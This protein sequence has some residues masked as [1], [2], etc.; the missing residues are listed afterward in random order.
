MDWIVHAPALRHLHMGLA[1]T[2]GLLFAARGA[3]TLRGHRWPRHA[4]IRQLSVVIDTGLL[5]AALR[6]LWVLHL[7]PLPLHWLQAKFVALLLY[8]VLG[9]LALKTL[10]R[11]GPRAIAYA[12]A[13]GCYL[14][15]ITVAVSHSPWGPVALAQR[16]F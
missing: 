5:A 4:W 3:A 15:I 2:S 11:P 9:T 16:M 12:L 6:L 13:L 7:N 10:R 8:I 14:Y 1:V